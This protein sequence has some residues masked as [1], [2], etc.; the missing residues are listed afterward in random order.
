MTQILIAINDNELSAILRSKLSQLY[1]VEVI[2]R[3]SAQEAISLMQILP[4]IG[5]IL[6]SEIIE[7]VA[8]SHKVS[9]FLIAKEKEEELESEVHLI[10]FGENA[11][12]YK[13]SVCI[14]ET[15]SS[16][17]IID[18]IGFLLGKT[19]INVLLEDQKT[20]REKEEQARR[21]REKAE[22]E[23]LERLALEKLEQEMAAQ[24]AE[25]EKIE[26]KKALE[27]RIARGN[28]RAA[29]IE[30]EKIEKEKRDKEEKERERLEKLQAERD[31]IASEKRDKEQAELE[32]T[33]REK[34]AKEQLE[35]ERIEKEAKEKEYLERTRVERESAEKEQRARKAKEEKERKEQ[36][37][38]QKEKEK[39][40]KERAE[41]ER[42]E[43]EKEVKERIERGKARIEKVIKE[44][45]EKEKAEKEQADR[46]AAEK[47][48]AER[49]KIEKI[50]QDRIKA[51]HEKKESEIAAKLKAENDAKESAQR[52][53]VEENEKTT[54]FKLPANFKTGG[55]T[56]EKILDTSGHGFLQIDTI[57]F[58]SLPEVTI[59][60]DVYT[61][62]KKGSGFEYNKKILTNT[63]I[64]RTD[65][66][67]ILIRSGNLYVS[68]KE[69]SKANAFL[70]G[71]FLRRFKSPNLSLLDRMKLNSDSYEILLDLFKTSA[72]DKYNVEIIKELIKSI[73]LLMKASDALTTYLTAQ[74]IHKLCYGYTHGYLTLYFLF[75]IVDRFPWSKD[76][77][78]NKLLYLSLFHDL[79]LNSDRMIKLHHHYATE[80]KNFSEE[81]KHTMI[82]HAD[83]AASVLEN[84]VKAPK[85]LTAL[86]REHHGIK[87]GKGFMDGL[88]IAIT[89]ASMAFIVIEDFVTHYLVALEKLEVNKIAGPTEAQLTVIFAELKKKYEKLTY[90]DVLL[91]LEKFFK[92]RA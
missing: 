9:E 37:I 22:Q 80:N 63:K 87:S 52:E 75:Q 2:I 11:S 89:P 54:V 53:A 90:R 86:I 66:E 19:E 41:L 61:R 44:K 24:R 84:I 72:F 74:N 18:Y 79:N 36:E 62:V 34:Q 64:I 49:D 26:K 45:S 50:K 68:Q 55:T 82:V 31:R 88:S 10:V 57:Y 25:M 8:A 51:I 21:E 85:E 67:R 30:Q 56:A 20:E 12:T 29:K 77:S 16:Q 6:C 17:K 5:I 73:D 28:A 14:P 4:D 23:R 35:K 39:R 15:T 69:Y 59:D 70:C 42:I 13:K 58:M 65:I 78:K 27:E 71:H 32:R 1:G 47:E 40:D 3:N 92:A 83:A 76:Q 43:K 60:F 7:R 48:K 91:E 38:A 46:E 81:E 33:K